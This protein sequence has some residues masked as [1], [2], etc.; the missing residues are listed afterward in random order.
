[1]YMFH[2]MLKL[3][4]LMKCFK[5]VIMEFLQPLKLI[6]CHLDIMVP[7]LCHVAFCFAGSQEKH[8]NTT[9]S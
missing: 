1:M 5:D 9:N 2:L 4:L 7:D 8:E 6:D 3:A